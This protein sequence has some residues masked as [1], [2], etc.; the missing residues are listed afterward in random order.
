MPGVHLFLSAKDLEPERNEWG[1]IFHDDEVFASKEVPYGRFKCPES[2]KIKDSRG[3][4]EL[5]RLLCAGLLNICLL[6][7]QVQH[8]GQIVAAVAADDQLTAQRAAKAVKVQ[9]EDLPAVVTIEVSHHSPQIQKACSK[10]PK[11]P[12]RCLRLFLNMSEP[13]S[14]TPSGSRRGTP[15]PPCCSPVTWTRPFLKLSTCSR[16]RCTWEARSTSTSRR[17]PA[18]PCPRTRTTSWRSSR[19]RRTRPRRR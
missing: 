2:V 17:R 16:V 7:L 3:G 8:V 15:S 18:S 12:T 5:G 1:A 19:P 13:C 10:R 11:L 4:G 14:R 6:A 9:Y